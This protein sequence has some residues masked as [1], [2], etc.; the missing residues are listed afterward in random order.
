MKK[1]K[2]LLMLMKKVKIKNEMG[3]KNGHGRWTGKMGGK[4]GQENE[5][6]VLYV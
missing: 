1:T 2:F 6:H 4:D 5:I 3:R